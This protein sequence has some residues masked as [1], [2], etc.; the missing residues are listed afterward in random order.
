M[1]AGPC[2][3][4]RQPD[5]GPARYR[6]GSGR[7]PQRRAWWPPV[8]HLH[9]VD[10][11]AVELS[12]LNRQTLCCEDDVGRPKADAALAWL[13]SLNPDVPV[14]APAARLDRAEPRPAA[15]LPRPAV[16]P[17]T[18]PGRRLGGPGGMAARAGAR[19]GAPRH[20]LRLDARTAASGPEP[21]TAPG[22]TPL[23]APLLHRAGGR[24]GRVP[25][26]PGHRHR[27]HRRHDPRRAVAGLATAHSVSRIADTVTVRVA[28]GGVHVLCR[29][30]LVA[31]P[32][33]VARPGLNRRATAG[34]APPL[35]ASGRPCARRR[36]RSRASRRRRSPRATP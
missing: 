1:S 7:V 8:G 29:A 12:N 15:R 36:R 5:T 27:P 32:P 21:A 9:C 13:R 19:G 31:R 16:G 23:G 10:P 28:V 17:G 33:P 3:P 14:A 18:A 25:G 4:P 11:D 34:R 24:H 20:G 35:P 6:A 22:R 30:H 26:R 2:R